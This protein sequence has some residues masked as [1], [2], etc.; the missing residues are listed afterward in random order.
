MSRNDARKMFS[1]PKARSTVDSQMFYASMAFLLFIVAAIIYPVEYRV[2]I[3]LIT[4]F[5]IFPSAMLGIVF[6]DVVR[7]RSPAFTSEI[8][9]SSMNVA[10]PWAVVTEDYV[11]ASAEEKIVRVNY[12][13]FPQGGYSWSL[14]YSAGGGRRGYVVV[15]TTGY[16]KVG[17]SIMCLDHLHRV[18][19]AALPPN[20]RSRLTAHPNFTYSS[21]IWFGLFPASVS[22]L[23]TLRY[24]YIP[25]NVEKQI[26]NLFNLIVRTN[27]DAAHSDSMRKTEVDR[28][29]EVIGKM[30]IPKT[31]KV[32][33]DI[34]EPKREG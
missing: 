28:S 18:S 10:E 30:K 26:G 3:W 24:N 12:A 14:F 22:M 21:P 9:H 4:G 33:G 23:K 6:A 27:E 15:P 11:D 25:A 17:A 19:L 5:I 34:E 32:P 20:V 7:M 2:N 13:I 29:N 31:V 1:I 8:A 16:I